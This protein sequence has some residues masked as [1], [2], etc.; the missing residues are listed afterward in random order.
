MASLFIKD[1][2]TAAL[3]TELAA[4]LGTTK[5]EIVRDLLRRRKAELGEAQPRPDFVEWLAQ[6]RR[7]HPMPKPTR[8][9]ADKAFHDWLSGE[10]DVVDP[11][12]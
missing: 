9:K 5:T 8:L 2:E 7:D 10:E 11:F 6:Y 12:R 3:A 4:R 1:S